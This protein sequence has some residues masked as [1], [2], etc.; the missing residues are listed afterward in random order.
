MLGP[1]KDLEWLS[2]LIGQIGKSSHTLEQPGYSQA[3]TF[4]PFFALLI[5]WVV[6]V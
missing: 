3:W 5:R 2:E 4:F 6:G 1:S